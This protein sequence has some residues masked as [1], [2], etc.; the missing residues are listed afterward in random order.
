MKIF[1]KTYPGCLIALSVFF[2]SLSCKKLIEIPPPSDRVSAEQAF[3]DSA[4]VLSVLA[5]IYNSF[6]VAGGDWEIH[7]GGISVF[8][9]LSADELINKDIYSQTSQSPFYTNSLLPNNDVVSTFWANAYSSLYTVNAALDGIAASDG[10][11][12]D[13]KNRLT[14]ELKTVRAF[15][16]F[17]LVNLYGGVPLVTD[18]N[19]RVNMQLPRATPDTVY[20]FIVSD[21]EEA[22]KDLTSDYPSYGRSR[23]NLFTATALLAKVEL[24][25]GH[26]QEAADFAGEVINS[27]I[28]SLEPDPN[29]V[30]LDGSTEAI[31]QLP[32]NRVYG[33]LQ[34]AEGALLIPYD[35]T[36]I[37]PFVF[38]P[39]LLN[40][41]E[42][43]DLRKEDWIDSIEVDGQTFFYPYKYKNGSAGTPT[44]VE[45]YMI[46]RLSEQYLIRA[47]ARA[48]LNQFNDALD[49]VN[50]I[51]ERAGLQDLSF[52]D[53]TTLFKAIQQERRVEF[54]TEWGNRWYD[55]KR[56][57]NADN[58]LGA[59]KPSWQSYDTLYPIP[60]SQIQS[61]PA[62]IQNPGYH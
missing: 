41:F 13:L 58:I 1:I 52:S 10:I 43:G 19:F 50:M 15:Y 60:L 4:N 49:D 35:T 46:F 47:E 9:G 5:G 39:S 45:D 8:T 12:I 20:K 30:F 56:T 27:E 62:L 21:L 32:C 26:W 6:N 37:P 44:T 29:N 25:L 53:Q 54:F 48:Q 34:S 61:N 24:Y 42:S 33:T 14:A 7:N 17:N 3:A 40:A 22:R 57:N 28:Y 23:P 51:R 11:S 36:V 59:I 31:W 18:V 16:Y 38:T 2:A 55:L